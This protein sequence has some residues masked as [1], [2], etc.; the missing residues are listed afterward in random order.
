MDEDLAII[1]E[2]TKREKMKNF[3]I[4]NK[5]KIYIGLGS[6]VIFIFLLICEAKT[7]SKQFEYFS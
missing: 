3:L 5:K 6:L 2:G 7:K 4:K 1:A